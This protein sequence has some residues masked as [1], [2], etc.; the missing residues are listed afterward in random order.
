MSDAYASPRSARRFAGLV[1]AI[2]WLSLV[3]QLDLLMV[4]AAA[5]GIP[6]AEALLIYF[7]FF[8][9]QT[10]ILA[11]IVTTL[12]AIDSRLWPAQ[13]RMEPA[14]VVY[15]V[16]GGAVFFLMLQ[17]VWSGHHGLQ[18]VADIL[19][20]CVTPILYAIFWLA[21]APKTG[22]R[23]RDAAI[24]LIYPFLYLIV[25][26][27]LAQWSG[28]YPYPFLDL[29]ELT[30]AQM[31]VNMTVLTAAFLCSGLIV[32]SIGRSTRMGGAVSD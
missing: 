12:A 17:S 31:A 18:W 5:L 4:Q 29:R 13:N 30:V 3:L 21:A 26:L 1:A 14:I 19:L 7:S 15:L 11:A 6:K 10:N 27:L 2:I 32:V 8:T 16:T 9:I 20:H 23:K 28:F 22:L 24:W 25:V